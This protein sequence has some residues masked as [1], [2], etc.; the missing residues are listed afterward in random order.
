M[1]EIRNETLTGELYLDGNVYIDCD[2]Q[3]ARMV[4]TGGGLPPAFENCR[5]DNSDF[6]FDGAAGRTLGFLKAMA[7][8]R[9]NMRYVVLGLLPELND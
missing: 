7:P 5:F 2:F 3:N 4:F 9:T 8:A 6:V 1:A